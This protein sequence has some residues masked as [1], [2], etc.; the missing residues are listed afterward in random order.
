MPKEVDVLPWMRGGE[1]EKANLSY[2]PISDPLS[3]DPWSHNGSSPILPQ[4]PHQDGD[5]G[6]PWGRL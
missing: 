6:G 2:R 5:R 3:I 1:H 4:L